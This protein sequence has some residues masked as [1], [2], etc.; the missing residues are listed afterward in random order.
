VHQPIADTLQGSDHGTAL[1][2]ASQRAANGH[3]APGEGRHVHEN[4]IANHMKHAS[5]ERLA[6]LAA[7][8]K[9]R[10]R[11]SLARHR[12]AFSQRDIAKD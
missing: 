7:P 8:M 1:H 2:R 11:N 4:G 9:G 12:S 5:P 6:M 10:H 3:G